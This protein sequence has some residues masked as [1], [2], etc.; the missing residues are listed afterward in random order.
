MRFLRA[1]IAA[2]VVAL[3]V[4]AGACASSDAALVT[5]ASPSN[6]ETVST[7]SAVSASTSN[8]T[9]APTP[10][11]TMTPTT[12]AAPGTTL[13]EPVTTVTTLPGRPTETGFAPLGTAGPLT[14]GHPAAVV[15]LIGFHESSHDG[16]QQID[17]AADTT[18]AGQVTTAGT[19]WLTMETRDRGTGSRTAVDIAVEP[20]TP[21]HAPVT[22]IV[23]RSGVYTLYC[24]HTDEFVVIEPDDRPGWE[25]KV[26]HIVDRQVAAG[27]RTIAG[28]SLLASSARQLPFESQ[29]DAF[30][31]PPAWPH[32][33]IEIVDPSIPD[34][35]S[36][37]GC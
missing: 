4:F 25:V 16:S 31:E 36:P 29:I 27:D 3:V 23:L 19:P 13:P 9:T 2:A 5:S 28:E 1:H 11:T 34:R 33:H 22:G 20:G 26:F 21:I 14:I 18:A 24:D 17:V 7:T 6:V 35:P 10:T 37:G 32:V 30:T 12:T 15:A 8:T